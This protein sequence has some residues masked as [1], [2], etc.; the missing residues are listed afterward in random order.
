MI[1]RFLFGLLLVCL[2][3]SFARTLDVVYSFG[4]IMHLL[5]QGLHLI[6]IVSHVLQKLVQK[7]KLKEAPLLLGMGC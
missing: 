2:P 6:E 1:F 7:G 4:T 5:A 3:F